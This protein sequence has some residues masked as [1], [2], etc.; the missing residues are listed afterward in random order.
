VRLPAILP[1]FALLAACGGQQATGVGPA[2]VAPAQATA[3]KIAP[4]IKRCGGTNGVSVSPCPLV[5]T[6]KTRGYAW[7][8]VIGSGVVLSDLKGY[9]LKGFCYNRKG[10]EICSVQNLA[11][12][13]TYWQASSGPHCGTAKPLKFYAYGTHG[14]IGYGYLEVINR[15]CS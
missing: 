8:N 1:A 9:Q 15:D 10:G 11:S 3:S 14:F 7:F 6:K 4:L 2:A 13:P 5:V 12:P